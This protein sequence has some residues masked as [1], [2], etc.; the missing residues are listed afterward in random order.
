MPIS[1]LFSH[2]VA[3]LC[4]GRLKNL[5]SKSS[6]LKWREHTTEVLDGSHFARF[7]FTKSTHRFRLFFASERLSP[8]NGIVWR[9]IPSSEEAVLLQPPTIHLVGICKRFYVRGVPDLHLLSQESK[10]C[11]SGSDV[12]SQPDPFSLIPWLWTWKSRILWTLKNH[13]KL[14]KIATKKN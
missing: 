10:S 13:R 9:L 8:K 5:R 11:C 7:D 3:E 1:S 4:P 14:T 12:M 2:G 6:A